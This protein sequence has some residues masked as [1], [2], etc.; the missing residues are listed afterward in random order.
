MWLSAEWPGI[1]GSWTSTSTSTTCVVVVVGSLN[2]VLTG[3]NPCANLDGMISPTC[4]G[5]GG[6]IGGGDCC[7][8]D[9]DWG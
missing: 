4:A 5:S 8:G 3:A 2:V 1:G 6:C 9:K 7:G